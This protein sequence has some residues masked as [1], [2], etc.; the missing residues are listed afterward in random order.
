MPIVRTDPFSQ[1]PLFTKLRHD[2]TELALATSF[3]YKRNECFF[4][5]S[6]WHNF[7]GRDPVTKNPL[8]ANAG[9]PN[10]ISCYAILKGEYI[11][12]E[13]LDIPLTKGDEPEWYEHPTL[14]SGIDIG[15]LPLKLDEKYKPIAINEMPYT[16]MVLRV[17][18]DLFVLGYPLGLD[19]SHGLPVWKRATV[20]SEP[21][22]SKPFFLVDTATRSGMSGSPVIHRYRGFYKNDPK[23]AKVRPDDWFGEADQFVGIYSGRLGASQLEAQLGIVWKPH[24]ID[25]IIDGAR[26]A[27]C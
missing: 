26:A 13:W 5:V 21:G 11:A 9:V 14:G 25:E 1:V 15:I 27:Q 6:N 2:A 4:L 7:A 23:A 12:R 10:T 16:D 20:A 8:S 19:G 3:L 17:S 24:L 22:I 18:H